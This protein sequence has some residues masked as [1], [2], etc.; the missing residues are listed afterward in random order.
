MVTLET[1]TKIPV[2]E[3]VTTLESVVTELELTAKPTT[4][5]P[6]NT[7]F[8]ANS[9]EQQTT[10]STEQ[11]TTGSSGQQMKTTSTQRQTTSGVQTMMITKEQTTKSTNQQ[12]TNRVETTSGL[13]EILTTS[14]TTSGQV[15]SG[16]EVQSTS[17][18]ESKHYYNIKG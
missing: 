8:A 14:F 6:V 11:R 12:A 3:K 5:K 15:Q 7:D 16:I 2:T 13:T 1:A 18:N 10:S 9:A 17:E 4:A